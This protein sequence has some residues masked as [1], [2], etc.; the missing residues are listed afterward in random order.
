VIT[1]TIAISIKLNPRWL[2][3]MSAGVR[4]MVVEK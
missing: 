1:I 2:F 4:P 3:T